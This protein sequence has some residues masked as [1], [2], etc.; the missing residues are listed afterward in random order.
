MK[1][2]PLFQREKWRSREHIPPVCPD[3]TGNRPT[4]DCYPALFPYAMNYFE[5]K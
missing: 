3:R 5:T 4:F 2:S 1:R